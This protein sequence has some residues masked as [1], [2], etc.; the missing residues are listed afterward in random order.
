MTRAKN[1]LYLFK[2]RDRE[3]EFVSELAVRIP[4]ELVD[5]EDIFAPLKQP[6]C[7]RS[8]SHREKGRGRITAQCGDRLLLEWKEHEP[9][10]FREQKRSCDKT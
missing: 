9:E 4:E 1:E 2:C 3:A 5:E 6:L 7:G 10:I 8:Y